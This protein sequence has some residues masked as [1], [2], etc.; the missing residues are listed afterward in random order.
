MYWLGAIFTAT[1]IPRSVLP[2]V[3]FR[4][5]DKAIHVLLYGGLGYLIARAMHDPP[6]TNRLRIILAVLLLVSAVGAL[7]E[8]HQQYIQGRRTDFGDWI[9]DSIGGLVGALL[10]D[11]AGRT[12]STRTA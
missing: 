8:W 6:R 9:A 12:K 1:S 3:R 4:L 2:D 10:W 5:A 11:T 7:D